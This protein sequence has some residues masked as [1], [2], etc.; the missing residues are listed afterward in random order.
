MKVAI[1]NDHAAIQLK[2]DIWEYLEGKDDVSVT[3]CGVRDNQDTD[4]SDHAWEVSNK[5]LS[6]EFDKGILL[7]GTGVG[8]C[9]AANKV[10]GIRA[11][12]CSDPYTARLARAHNDV[13][14][15]CI[16]A[17]VVGSELAKLIV[18]AFLDTPFE[19]GR[20]SARVRKVMELED[21]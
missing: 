19:G 4:Y 21:R 14:V 1:G 11:V 6:G 16:G 20:H 7:C 18:D 15:L 3:D 17:R 9:I 12:V 5:V 10:R 2:G 8:M 13:N